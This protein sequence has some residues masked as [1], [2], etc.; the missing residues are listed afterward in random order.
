MHHIASF[1]GIARK[2]F[3][4]LFFIPQKR[5]DAGNT[6]CP[7][8]DLFST[9]LLFSFVKLS[10]VCIL[11]LLL[12][13]QT[14]PDTRENADGSVFP[15]VI[16]RICAFQMYRRN[17]RRENGQKTGRNNARGNGLLGSGPSTRTI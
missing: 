14:S 1:L 5:S 9:R 2:R 10:Y 17:R 4:K 7:I 15:S 13:V 12:K 8:Y 6:A 16:A 3:N 11:S